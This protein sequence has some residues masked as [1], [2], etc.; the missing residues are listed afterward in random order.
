MGK[1]SLLYITLSPSLLSPSE[2]DRDC[3]FRF[4]LVVLMPGW[5]CLLSPP[6]PMLC[7]CAAMV[8]LQ[9]VVAAYCCALEMPALPFEL[10]PNNSAALLLP[11]LSFSPSLLSPGPPLMPPSIPR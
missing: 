7:P 8:D 3:D 4:S 5:I 6:S 2:R 1:L 9:F 10:P 11:K